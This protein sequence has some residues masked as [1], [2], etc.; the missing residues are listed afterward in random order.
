MWTHN[1]QKQPTEAASECGCPGR[2]RLQLKFLWQ[3]EPSL[4]Q[5]TYCSCALS[6]VECIASLHSTLCTAVSL[7]QSVKDPA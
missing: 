6:G 2:R 5:L 7:I 1:L 3:E 4:S